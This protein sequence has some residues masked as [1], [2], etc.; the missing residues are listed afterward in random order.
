MAISCRLAIILKLILSFVNSI[1]RVEAS[2]G[3]AR[4]GADV[5]TVSKNIQMCM[6]RRGLN[7]KALSQKADISESALSRYI[8]GERSPRALTLARIAAA[9]DVTME[10]LLGVPTS[11]DTD[12]LEDAVRLIAR[13]SNA[14]S[15]DQK[16]LIIQSLI[17]Q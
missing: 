9:L 10:D 7:Q 13:N 6:A 11:Q 3:N 12:N 5:S 17:S 4:N 14:L 1:C 8:N 16:K 2:F 15:A